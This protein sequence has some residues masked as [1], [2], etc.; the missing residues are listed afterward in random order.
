MAD[1]LPFKGPVEF[2]SSVL[3]TG[4]FKAA[5]ASNTLGTEL[6]N[7]DTAITLATS[8]HGSSF[9]CALTNQAKTVNLPANVTAADIGTK[10]QIV[11]KANL[12]ASGVLTLNANT[13]NIFSA[14]TMAGTAGQTTVVADGNSNNRLV[15]TGANTNSA[16]GGGSRITAT[17]IAAGVWHL[18]IFSIPL[19]TGNDAFAFSDA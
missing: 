19:G 15:I 6:A 5:N 12:V 13:G 2:N 11:Q 3:C 10:I 8:D 17:V 18:E 7:D 16:F 1:R 14:N 9:L 4:T